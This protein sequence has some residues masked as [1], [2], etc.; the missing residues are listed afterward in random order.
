MTVTALE[1][2]AQA[3]GSSEKGLQIDWAMVASIGGAVLALAATTAAILSGYIDQYLSAERQQY[4]EFFV[5]GIAVLVP[6]LFAWRRAIADHFLADRIGAEPRYE[7]VSGWSALLLVFVFLIIAYLVWWA[8]GSDDAN[9]TIHSEW[10]MWVVIGVSAAFVGVASAPL[11]PRIVRRLGL[12]KAG[13]SFATWLYGPVEWIGSVLSAVD[14]FLVFAVANAAGTNRDNFFLRYAILLSMIGACAALGYYWTAPFAFVP[15]AWGFI[16]AFAVSRR[17]AWIEQDRELA[18]LNPT[19]SQQH[20]R[21]GFGQNLRDEALIVFLSM[22]LFVPLALRQA[23][24]LAEA[25]G[26]ELFTLRGNA[27]VHSLPMWIAYY[28]TELAKA[29][30]FVDWAE[31]YHV[32]GDAPV[33]A[34]NPIALHAVF[35]TRVLIDLVFLA[36]LL[37]AMSAASRDA[38]QRDLFYRKRAISR[39]DPFV[40]P[41]ALRALVRKNA[42]GAWERNGDEFDNFPKYDLN[43]L[44]ELT[45]HRDERVRQA[46]DFLLQRDGIDQNPHYRLSAEAAKKGVKPDAIQ[47]IIYEIEQTRAVPNIYQLALARRRLN[48]KTSMTMIRR[49]I[50][51]LVAEAPA[52]R[53]RTEALIASMVGEHRE[54]TYQSRGVALNALAP[55]VGRNLRVRAAVEQVAAHDTARALRDQ[56]AQIIA[57]NPMTPD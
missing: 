29:V 37:Q 24:L 44:V 3:E 52:S 11:V 32:E 6:V 31:V 7:H 35:G 22:F 36:A 20:I 51:G 54:A 40:E 25:S 5:F 57:S 50:I 13:S 56:A 27:D 41:D 48:S 9:R 30:P 55:D 46:A 2:S 18:M 17:W 43:R 4:A 33:T 15:I 10:G 28:G 21:V 45:A 16:V 26:I 19:L 47:K 12:E 42:D 1:G 38:Q 53:D 49:Q 39:L 8:A 34:E 23:E 14:G